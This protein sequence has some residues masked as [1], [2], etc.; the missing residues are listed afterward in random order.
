MLKFEV[1]Y[2][3]M[4]PL[5]YIPFCYYLLKLKR[6]HIADNWENYKADDEVILFASSRNNNSVS[7]D[8]K[9]KTADEKMPPHKFKGDAL[10][11]YTFNNELMYFEIPELEKL[12]DINAQ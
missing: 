9:A 6:K 2:Y 12:Q 5:T 4:F 10:I 1:I 11:E 7:T 3:L 8:E